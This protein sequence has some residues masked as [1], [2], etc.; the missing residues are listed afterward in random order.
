MHYVKYWN[1]PDNLAKSGLFIDIWDRFV[2]LFIFD[3]FMSYLILA[4]LLSSIIII[5]FKL[6]K[7]MSM[8]RQ[9][10]ITLNY[11]FAVIWGFV[12]WQEPMSI[13]YIVAKPWFGYSFVAGFFFIAGYILIAKSTARAGVAVT[14]VS[15]KM[16]V[17]IPVLMGLIFFVKM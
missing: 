16:S 2:F 8:D 10:V 11:L 9:Q 12:I 13:S 15:S 6:M 14:A 1:L 7:Q 3:G 5:S 4:I 17:V